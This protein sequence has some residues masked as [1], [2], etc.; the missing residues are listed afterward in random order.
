MARTMIDRMAKRVV[1]MS[2]LRM[3]ERSNSTCYKI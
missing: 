1:H 2:P 3:S